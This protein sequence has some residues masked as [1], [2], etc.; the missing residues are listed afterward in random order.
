MRFLSPGFLFALI[1]VAIPIIIHLFNFRKFKKVYFSNVRFLKNVEMQTSSKRQLKD[2]LILASRILGLIFLVLAFAR[3][4]IPAASHKN[5]FQNQVLSIYIDNSFSMEAQNKNGTLLDEAKRRAKEIASA[6]SLN[7]KFQ[8]LTND[9]EGKNQRLLSLEEFKNAVDEIE[10][11][12]ANKNIKQIIARQKDVFSTEPNSRKSIYLISDFQKNILADDAIRPDSSVS[13]RLIRLKSNAQ[14]NIS[15]D[16]LWFNSAIHKP[17]DFEKII[18][19]LKNNSD[20]E[21]LNIPI[22]LSINKEQKALGSISIKAR[23][24]AIDTLSFSGLKAGWQEAV[25]E[26]TDYPFIFD[27]KF[28]FSFR[29][30]ESMP[31]LIINGTKENPYLNALFQSDKFF[32]ISNNLEGNVS[33]SDLDAY[34]LIILNELNVLNTGLSQTL[35]EYCKNGGTLMLFPSLDVDQSGL[36]NFLQGLNTDVPEQLISKEEKIT[37]I[38][39]QHPI[40]LGVFE[41]NTPKMDLPAVKKYLKFS[42]LSKTK[43]KNILELPGNQ[44]FLSEYTFGSGKIY[45]SAVA[46]N[47]ES[48][49]L[50]KHAIFVPIMYQTALLSIKKQQLFYDLNS[51]T[52]INLPKIVLNPNQTLKLRKESFESIPDMRQNDNL[53]Q[54]NISDQLRES[55]NY[56]LFKGDSLIS[57][58]SFNDAGSE[59]DLSYASNKEINANFGATKPEMIEPGSESIENTIKSVNQGFSLWKLCLI[60][61]LLFFALEILLIRFY[62]KM[63]IK[64]QIN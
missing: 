53:S 48:S 4:Y 31:I 51:E 29:V 23:S 37:S 60:L 40:F 35:Q 54:I 56:Q 39:L 49:N 8:V 46:L 7:D 24:T 9:L 2:R 62:D 57:T 10:I 13:I 25:M 22:K 45:L 17:G 28:F 64:P 30:E 14:A 43:R 18:V 16:S 59:S 11:S 15:I 50:P 32:R 21:A 19:R 12:S 47:D 27:D 5:S 34:S 41:K 20:E 58:L 44:L 3:P 33:Y 38:N 42:S 26:I 52:L 6:H 61:A 63:Q 55:G 36:K 1:T